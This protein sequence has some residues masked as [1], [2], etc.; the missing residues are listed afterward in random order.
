MSRL[1][2]IAASL[3]MLA[4]GC[5]AAP[6][7]SEPERTRLALEKSRIECPRE[8]GTRIHRADGS[9]PAVP[10]RVFTIEDLERTGA[11]TVDEALRMLDPSFH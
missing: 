7:M 4:A 9:C 3:A 10:G 11:G 5:A 2:P 8:T 1:V 6:E